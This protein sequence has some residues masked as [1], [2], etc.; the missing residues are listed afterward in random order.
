[1]QNVICQICS[2]FQG[3]CLGTLCRMLFVKLAH[4][5]KAIVLVFYTKCYLSH[6][7]TFRRQWSWYFMQSHICQ[8]CSFFQGYS[9]GFF[10]QNHICQICSLFK[11]Y[12]LGILC[13]ML[14]VTFAHFSKAIVLA[15]YAKC[16]LSNLLIFPRL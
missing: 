16:Y 9:L 10:M 7:L 1:M 13:K 11:G 5:S 6:L 2:F 15:Y 4:F 14:F 3:Y 12:R 8:I